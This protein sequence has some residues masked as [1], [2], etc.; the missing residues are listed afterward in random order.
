MS[1]SDLAQWWAS[2][3]LYAFDAYYDF[4]ALSWAEASWADVARYQVS[5]TGSS[6]KSFTWPDTC[7]GQSSAGAVFWTTTE[8]DDDVNA[9]TTGLF[10]NLSARLYV[11]TK[12]P[13]YLDA[14]VAAYNFI[15]KFLYN[16]STNLVNDSFALKTCSTSS[17]SSI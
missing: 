8:T 4:D 6:V 5:G 1:D 14:A 9:I 12:D 10:M 16:T 13:K 15:S 11:V 3:A 17:A 2:S 7:S